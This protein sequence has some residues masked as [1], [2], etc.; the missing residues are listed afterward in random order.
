[1]E[2]V[3]G[4]FH[5]AHQAARVDGIDGYLRTGQLSRSLSNLLGVARALNPSHRTCRPGTESK[6]PDGRKGFRHLRFADATVFRNE[7]ERKCG[8]D[9]DHALPAGYSSKNSGQTAHGSSCGLH[10]PVLHVSQ[11]DIL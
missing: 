2:V 8:S 3:T 4:G 6:L 9:P 5:A 10:S 7:A 11:L 1:R